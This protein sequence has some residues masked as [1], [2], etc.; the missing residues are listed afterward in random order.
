M[1]Q[2]VLSIRA[3][4]VLKRYLQRHTCTLL[5]ALKATESASGNEGLVRRAASAD[6]A[7]QMSPPASWQARCFTPM[8]VAIAVEGISVQTP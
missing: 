8:P 2:E 4:A 6:S 5:T 1:K 7:T 3:R